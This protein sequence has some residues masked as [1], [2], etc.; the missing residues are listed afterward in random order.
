MKDKAF[1]AALAVLCLTGVLFACSKEKE[2]DDLAARTAELYYGYLLSGDVGS[3]VEGMDGYTQLPDAYKAE[4]RGNAGMY[5]EQQKK[6]HGGLMA[7]TADRCEADS[8]VGEVIMTFA[9][10]DGTKEQVLVPMVR[11]HGLW[12]MR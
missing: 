6:V 12:L 9:Y 3:F 4:L 1:R 10:G 7:V 8:T 11:R 5:A 2:P